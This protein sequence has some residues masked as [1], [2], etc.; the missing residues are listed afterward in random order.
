VLDFEFSLIRY[1]AEFGGVTLRIIKPNTVKVT[2]VETF[3]ALSQNFEK[4]LISSYLSV[5]PYVR[6]HGTTLLPLD[7]FSMKFYIL[8]NFRKIFR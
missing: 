3:V 2:G 6:A 8:D 4:L 5:C 1:I 7:R